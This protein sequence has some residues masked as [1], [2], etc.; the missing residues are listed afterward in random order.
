MLTEAQTNVKMR[1]TN[2][3]FKITYVFAFRKN[4]RWHLDH[5]RC[6]SDV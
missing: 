2:I 6:L 1:K 3:A 4:I 5:R